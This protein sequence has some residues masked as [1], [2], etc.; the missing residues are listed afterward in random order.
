MGIKLVPNWSREA[1]STLAALGFREQARNTGKQLGGVPMRGD[2]ELGNG[3]ARCWLNVFED[4]DRAAEAEQTLRA[5]KD[6]ARAIKSGASD[7]RCVGPVLVAGNAPRGRLSAELFSSVIE[8]VET[9]DAP[10][11]PAAADEQAE[12]VPL[13]PADD[14]EPVVESRTPGQHDPLEQLRKLGELRDAGILTNE[15]FE[16]K[17]ANLLDL[18]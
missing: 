14:L 16:Q 13:S 7:F 12:P 8:E 10:R 11:Q 5:K 18:I 3:E 17:K 4:R 9:L 2:V 6:I 15:E 1:A